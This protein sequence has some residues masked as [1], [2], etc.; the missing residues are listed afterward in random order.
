MGVVWLDAASSLCCD[1]GLRRAFFVAAIGA[2]WSMLCLGV[3]RCRFLLVRLFVVAGAAFVVG[4]VDVG[5]RFQSMAYAFLKDVNPDSQRWRVKVRVVR[6]SQFLTKDQPPRVQRIDFIMLDEKNKSMEC[7]IPQRWIA[8]HRARLVEDHVYFIHYFEVVNARSTHRPVDH[9]YLARLTKHTEITEVTTVAPDF[10]LY[11]CTICSFAELAAKADKRERLLDGIGVLKKCG[12]PNMV[13]TASGTKPLRNVIITDGSETASVALWGNHANEFEA[14]RYMD[15]S[16]Q[17]PVILLF[18][19]VTTSHF[20]G[21]L[22]LQ[23]SPT[24]RWYVNPL[25]PETAMLRESLSKTL[26]PAEWLGAPPQQA[27]P[28]NVTVTQLAGFDNPHE[29]WGNTYTVVAKIKELK[30]NEP[31]W[32]MSCTLCKK[33]SDPYGDAYKCTNPKCTG[34]SA[35]PRYRITFFV[36]EPEPPAEGEAPA[37]EFICF[38]PNGDELTGVPVDVLAAA[39][40]YDQAVIPEHIT[41]LY[42]RTYEFG[43]SVR[44]GSLQNDNTTFRVDTVRNAVVPADQA[45]ALHP[46]GLDPAGAPGQAQQVEAPAGAPGQA[47]QAEANAGTPEIAAGASTPARDVISSPIA[48]YEQLQAPKNDVSADDSDSDES[49]PPEAHAATEAASTREL[50]R[51]KRNR[52]GRKLQMASSNDDD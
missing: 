43:V 30:G 16:L 28:G 51:L 25:L 45:A 5:L 3:P 19:G 14:Q 32:Y 48:Q 8:T 27:D 26:C 31:W 4:L 36:T 38:G 29:V 23:G 22:T 10:P 7:N 12:H 11:A 9:D 49:L 37:V 42:G 34:K 41:R 52:P 21:R 35:V 24:C 1:L 6:F 15:M 17:G 33:R 40:G 2:V 39:T 44:G 46:L 47:Q 50:K 13:T 20:Q 18:C